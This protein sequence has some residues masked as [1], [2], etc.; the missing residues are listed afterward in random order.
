MPV[1]KPPTSPLNFTPSSSALVSA[2][3]GLAGT[4]DGLKID[5]HGHEPAMTITLTAPPTVSTLPLSSIARLRIAA[6]PSTPKNPLN[7]HDD[8][9]CAACHV[10]PPSSQASTAA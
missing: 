4:T 8:V 5:V 1:M 3:L 9:P 2:A 7:V 10:T 6:G